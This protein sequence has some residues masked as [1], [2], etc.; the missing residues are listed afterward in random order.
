M[1]DE[2]IIEEY[3]YE[4]WDCDKCGHKGIRGD[5]DR[6]KNCGSPRND[7]TV[8]YRKE[9]AE[10]KV[11]DA[12]EAADFAAGP[13]WL[14]SFC[15]TL[16]S[17]LLGKC[18][19]C[20]A[21]KE[22]SQANY[23]ELQA[24][25]EA[26]Q[27]ANQKV[28]EPPK[29]SNKVLYWVLGIV[30]FISVLVWWANRTSEE[31]YK[32]NQAY[33]EIT[34]PV[35]RYQTARLSDWRD[36]MKGDDI[37]QIASRKEIRRYEKRQI[38]VKNENYTESVQY[39]SGSKRECSTSYKSTGSGA[40]K[41]TTSCKNVPTYSTRQESRTRQVPVYQDFPIFDTKIDY[42]A[43]LYAL[44]KN[45]VTKGND[46]SPK[47]P[48]VTLGTGE[49]NKPD[50]QMTALETYLIQLKAS[51]KKKGPDEVILTTPKE[52]FVSKYKVKSEVKMKVNNMGNFVLEK[53]EEL[54]KGEK[55]PF[56]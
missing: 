7:S 17:A 18:R 27:Q 39:Q 38:G 32:V 55:S 19:S 47:P 25:K 35:Q 1:S 9:E 41:K 12:K 2:E 50:K 5:V 33:W 51:A 48:T 43:R 45:E 49:K 26:K 56:K 4:Y 44:F 13:D 37:Q 21:S 28:E 36:E 22:D 6:C 14:C 46:N 42:S 15:S 53:G 52:A 3:V 23:F 8:F 20:G 11:E 34:V 10:E 40:S 24:K 29:K 54:Y 30:G 16:N 31:L